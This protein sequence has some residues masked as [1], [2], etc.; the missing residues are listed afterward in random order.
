MPGYRPRLFCVMAGTVSAVPMG[1]DGEAVIPLK[2]VKILKEKVDA[3]IRALQGSAQR[4][5]SKDKGL[6]QSLLWDGFDERLQVHGEPSLTKKQM[7]DHFE[8]AR[9]KLEEV[10]YFSG[11]GW[12]CCPNHNASL[13]HH[14]HSIPLLTNNRSDIDLF[15]PG[16]QA[17]IGAHQRYEATRRLRSSISR[18]TL[19]CG[20]RRGA[21]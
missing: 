6:E 15:F 4:Q 1:V 3:L 19:R 13:S 10:R 16:W 20:A 9:S 18:G 11:H 7:L 5:G 8:E 12:L 14:V 17:F 21:L 2:E